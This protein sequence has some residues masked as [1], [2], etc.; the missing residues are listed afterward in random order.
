M[1]NALVAAKKLQKEGI[2]AI[3]VNNHTIK[4]LDGATILEVAKQT[5]A[6][7][8]VE[9]HQIA[10]GMGS[11]VAEFL[12]QNYPVPIEFVGVQDK[13]GQSG[14]PAELVEH[15]GMG[16]SGIMEKVKKVISRK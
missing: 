12:A 13:Y 9:E 6:V 8:T 7:V 4:P 1:H 11:A 15:Y 10:G 5:G 14:T 16:V 2:G 3:V